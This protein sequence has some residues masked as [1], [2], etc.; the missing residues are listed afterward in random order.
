[1]QASTHKKIVLAGCG[2]AALLGVVT[3]VGVVI[4]V[5]E[6]PDLLRTDLATE[7][8]FRPEYARAALDSLRAPDLQ[9]IGGA[10][11]VDR[12]TLRPRIQGNGALT[13]AL[14]WT[15]SAF[16]RGSVVPFG[17][18]FPDGDW[19]RRRW[20]ASGDWDVVDSLRAAALR[21]WDLAATL[22]SGDSASDVTAELWSAMRVLTATRAVL[23]RARLADVRGDAAEADTLVRAVITIGRHLQ[24]DYRLYHFVLGARMEREAL[25]ALRAI[26]EQGGRRR[27]TAP[28]QAALARA[29][30]LVAAAERAYRLLTVA[31]ALGDNCPVL[32]GLAR[33]RG[34]PLAVRHQAVL[35]IGYGWAFASVE[36]AKLD[37]RRSTALADLA[38]AAL[39]GELARAV[40]GARRVAEFSVF[41]RFDVAARQQVLWRAW[42]WAG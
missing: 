26:E 17:D 15:D 11:A 2:C 3:A 16:A 5:L 7:Q 31:G 27:A 25:H 41:K 37:A 42:G 9:P 20:V 12:Y 24:R 32:E 22:P 28:T 35:A 36:Q 33:D 34:L 30:Q 1:M 10:P 40:R 14:V 21:P 18:T 19:R 13:A 23:A 6:D 8:H 38:R 29:N 39:P 4:A